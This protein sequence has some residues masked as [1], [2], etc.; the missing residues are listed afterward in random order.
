[1]VEEKKS[2][3]DETTKKTER[4]TLYCLDATKTN[5]HWEKRTHRPNCEET[6]NE[7]HN[8]KHKSGSRAGCDSFSTRHGKNIKIK[9][10]LRFKSPNSP[11]VENTLNSPCFLNHEPSRSVTH[12]FGNFEPWKD[13]SV[14]YSCFFYKQKLLLNIKGEGPPCFLFVYIYS[15]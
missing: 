5:W 9:C 14:F 15:V 12:I 6:P 1:M 7:W 2:N 4:F 13:L 10:Y 8:E 3:T 11:S